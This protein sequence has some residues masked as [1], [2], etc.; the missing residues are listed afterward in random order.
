MFISFLDLNDF[1]LRQPS[2]P[3]DKFVLMNKIV[4]E[5]SIILYYSNNCEYCPT[6]KAVFT[7]LAQKIRGC[8]VG[9]VHADSNQP[10]I[11]ASHKTTT[12]INYV[13]LIL[14]YHKGVPVRDYV[15]EYAE[16]NLI[17]FIQECMDKF[18]ATDVEMS[19]FSIG[20]P[21]TKDVCYLSYEKAYNGKQ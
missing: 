12:P 17:K 1:A 16:Q 19:K 4:N 2:K 13:P 8:K 5:P 11:E 20:K 9:L 21:K 10:L 7:S 14:F 6:I 3:G 15:G 18:K